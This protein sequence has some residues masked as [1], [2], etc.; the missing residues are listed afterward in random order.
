[1]W[2]N[3]SDNSGLIEGKRYFH[4]VSGSGLV[5]STLGSYL[6]STYYLQGAVLSFC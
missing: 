4:A 2:L 3:G 1:M 5:I 6:L